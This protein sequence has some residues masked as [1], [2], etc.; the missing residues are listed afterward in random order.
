MVKH[1]AYKG[2]YHAYDFQDKAHIRGNYNGNNSTT[3]ESKD[4]KH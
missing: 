1:L 2:D 4:I 3:Y